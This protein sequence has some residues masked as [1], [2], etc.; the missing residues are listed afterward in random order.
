[1]LKSAWRQS[2]QRLLM[3]LL[4]PLAL[5]AGACASNKAGMKSPEL[6]ARH[7]LDEAPGVPVEN[8]EKLD[9]AIPNLYDPDK[10]FDFEDCVYLTIQQSPMLVNSAV[11]IE[12]KK[13]AVTDAV[14]KYLP[15]PRLTV[16]V[17]NNITQLNN[18]SKDTPGN[19]GRPMVRVGFDANIPN[20]VRSYF[21]HKVQ[22]ILLNLAIST[23]RKAVAQAI[24]NIAAAYL[25]LQ[26]QREIVEAQKELIPLSKELSNY[27]RH[28]ES[29]AGRQ[30]VELDLARQGEREREL[31]MEKTNMQ[32]VMDRT[33]LKILAGV[34]PHQQFQ[35]NTKNADSILAGFDGSRLKWEDRWSE[36]EDDLLLRTQIKLADYNIMLAWAQYVPNMTLS[37]NNY[38]PAGQSNP[39]SGKEDTF[40]HLAFDFPLLDWG[41]RY[42]GVQTARMQKAQ[43]FHD[44]ANKRN[45]YCNKWLEAEQACALAQTEYK[46]Q[47]NRFETAEMQYKEA[48]ISFDEGTVELPVVID[49]REAM[50]GARISLIKAELDYKLAQL[51]WM[52]VAN[53][54]AER[55]LGPPAKEIS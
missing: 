43:A 42:R 8:K 36:T 35:I 46:L 9:A 55:F 53:V 2:G 22:N 6:P 51:K 31:T 28:V 34:N 27:W 52:D 15:E 14:W 44:M 40:I 12:I 20:P 23:H 50:I 3:L 16:T 39:P 49:T 5:L 4:L 11:D 41:R 19:Y 21:E 17:T 47:K 38:P 25:N 33:R 54:L 13:L 26:A 30:G 45:E 24:Y 10:S 18:D 37:V 48:R 29:V 1:M 32:E 7:W